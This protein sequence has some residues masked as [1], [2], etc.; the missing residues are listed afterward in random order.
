MA[1]LL[2]ASLALKPMSALGNLRVTA[3]PKVC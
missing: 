1:A 2:R 3:S